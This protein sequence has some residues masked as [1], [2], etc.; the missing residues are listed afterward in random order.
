MARFLY[1]QFCAG[2]TLSIRHRYVSAGLPRIAQDLGAS[3]AQLHIAFRFTFAGM[4]AAMLFAGRA[5]DKSGR[6][7]VAIFGSTIIYLASLLCAQAQTSDPSSS[8]VLSCGT[9]RESCYVVAFAVSARY[10][11]RSSSRRGAV[12]V[13][14]HHLHYP[15]PGPALGHLIMLKYPWQPCSYTMTGMGVM[16]GLLGLYAAGN[17]ANSPFAY[18]AGQKMPRNPC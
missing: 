6:K 11:R 16:V 9:G 13:K 5:A 4:A 17:A 2:F 12:A 8:G 14:W 10:A 15:G 1:L 18:L 3:E 7:P